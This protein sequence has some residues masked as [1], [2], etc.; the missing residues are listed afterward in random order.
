MGEAL[1]GK[2]I[3]WTRVIEVGGKNL[4]CCSTFFIDKLSYHHVSL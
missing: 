1:F 4:Q 2:L 3:L